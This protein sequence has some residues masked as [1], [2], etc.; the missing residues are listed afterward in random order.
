VLG[1]LGIFAYVGVEVGLATTMV[2]YFS[3]FKHGGLNVLLEPAAQK[4][5]VFYWLGALVGRL[6]G[7]WL[8]SKIRAG[9]LLGIFGLAAAALVVVAIF[10]AGHIAIGSLI[11]VGFF[12]SIMFPN[13]FTLGIVGLG[14]LTSKG[15]GLIM[16]AVVGG[17]VIPVVIGYLVDHTTY[18]IALILP[19]LCYLYIA[20]Y[21][22]VGSKPTRTV[23]A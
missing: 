10:S 7:S 23:T 4:L 13:I 12:N 20:F 2:L 17:A 1:A 16:T 21:G 9:K 6:L 15:S 3:D 19:V 8:V 18:Q 14:P 5:V 22:F 11:L